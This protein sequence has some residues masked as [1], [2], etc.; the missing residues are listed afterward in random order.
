LDKK[1]LESLEQ[2]KFEEWIYVDYK[3]FGDA[4]FQFSHFEIDLRE[5]DS[6]YRTLYVVYRYDTIVS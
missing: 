2:G 1:V 4:I 3:D 5:P 6:Q